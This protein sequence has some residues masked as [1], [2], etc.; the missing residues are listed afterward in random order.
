MAGSVRGG[1]FLGRKAEW[2]IAVRRKQQQHVPQPRV[3]ARPHLWIPG[4]A[5]FPKALRPLVIP[6]S[7][8]FAT[9]GSFN[10]TVPNHNSLTADA[11][12]AGGGGGGV[13]VHAGSATPGGAGGYS[14]F[15]APT[16]NVVG[17]GGSGGPNGYNGAVGASGTGLNGDGNITG[18]G[19]AGGVGGYAPG[20]GGGPAGGSAQGGSG[21][22]GGRAYKT[23]IE[24][25]LVPLSV[26]TIV[27][28][29]G[30]SPGV[31][32][33]ISGASG[34]AYGAAGA[35]YVSWS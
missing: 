19:A 12:G 8:T 20:F 15:N 1:D 25:Q 33:Q 29:P 11:R 23:W 13:E 30:G 26:I 27:V 16:G 10:F 32:E 28:G 18:G 2:M 3:I 24:G 21:G 4:I 7:Q 22:P 17:Y 14:Y 31:S 35:V 6:G 34:P 5:P 9:V